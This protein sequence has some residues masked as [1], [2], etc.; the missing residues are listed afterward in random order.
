MLR[1]DKLVLARPAHVVTSGA[2]G[3]GDLAFPSS[4]RS[5][6]STPSGLV[7]MD[8][9]LK[10]VE[11]NGFTVIDVTPD[12]LTFSVFMWRPPQPVDVIDTMEPVLVHEVPRQ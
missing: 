11:K 3:T 8:E 1:S 9:V 10:P 5:I 6:E 7:G 4:F 12:K 2:L